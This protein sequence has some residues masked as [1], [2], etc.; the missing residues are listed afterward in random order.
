MEAGGALVLGQGTEAG[1]NNG[2]PDDDVLGYGPVGGLGVDIA[3]TPQL[4]FTLGA[5]STF[6]F[7]DVALDNADPGALGEDGDDA[8]Y[9]AL[10]TIYG[11]LRYAFRA[12]HTPVEI[13]RLDCPAELIAGDS[14]TFS[15]R[16]NA[17]ATPPVSISWAWGDGSTGAGMTATHT[18]R[19]PG[20]YT[21][22]L[23]MENRYGFDSCE[24]AVTITD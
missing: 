4:G 22:T 5:Q 2:S 20:T 21:A 1:R 14:G 8:D 12:P 11:G 18:Y 24:G 13:T 15:V 3:L 19:T 10:T 23:R 7:P 9:D 17:D 6:V 16:T